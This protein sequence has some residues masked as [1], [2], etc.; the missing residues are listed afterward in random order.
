MAVHGVNAFT[1][2]LR[3]GT[4]KIRE[5]HLVH[6]DACSKDSLCD[7]RENIVV[8]TSF[9]TAGPCV[10]SILGR[11]TS[12]KGKAEHP[13]ACI[14]M[15]TCKVGGPT[16]TSALQCSVFPLCEVWLTANVSDHTWTTGEA[17]RNQTKNESAH[18]TILGTKIYCYSRAIIYKT[19]WRNMKRCGLIH[20]TSDRF[21]F[22][23]PARH[24]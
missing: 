21:G 24:P 15:K 9:G 2:L 14:K 11:A 8:V 20:G 12:Y 13:R 1:R 10:M 17:T 4:R 6:S 3:A 16:S 19:C 7:W 18:S 22:E 5:P 23:Y